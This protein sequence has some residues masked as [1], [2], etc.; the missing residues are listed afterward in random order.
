ME[1]FLSLGLGNYAVN[2]VPDDRKSAVYLALY[3]LVSKPLPRPP[4]VLLRV[5]SLW[6]MRVS[7]KPV[8]VEASQ[9]SDLLPAEWSGISATVTS[10]TGM[11]SGIVSQVSSYQDKAHEIIWCVNNIINYFFYKQQLALASRPAKFE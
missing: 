8:C 2:L 7:V 9:V 6:I 3:N 5:I 1:N 4:M 11:L 10:M